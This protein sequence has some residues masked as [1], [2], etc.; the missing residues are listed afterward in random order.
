ML[1]EHHNAPRPAPLHRQRV[2]A[3]GVWVPGVQPEG[4]LRGTEESAPLGVEGDAAHSSGLQRGAGDGL[5][6]LEVPE[7][8]G[9]VGTARGEDKLLRVE[10]DG[11]D[12]SCVEGEVCQHLPCH[13]VPQLFG[14]GRGREERGGEEGMGGERRGGEGRGGEG[15]G[16]EGRGEERRGREGKRG[17]RRGVEERE[18]RRGKG[19]RGEGKGGE[20]RGG[21]G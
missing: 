5:E 3:D 14:E 13:K 12:S 10:A 4:V 19:R 16:R 20:R 8:D 15:R 1:P 7:P 9:A 11:I 18:E 6:L 2:S 17:E 21:E